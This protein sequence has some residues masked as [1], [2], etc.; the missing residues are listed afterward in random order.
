M[1]LST[2]KAKIVSSSTLSKTLNTTAVSADRVADSMREGAVAGTELA[3][4]AARTDEQASDLARSLGK[5]NSELA[6]GAA[7]GA[8]YSEALDSVAQEQA[9]ASA[10]SALLESRIES[11]G[12][13]ATQSALKAR[14]FA[15]ALDGI[16]DTGVRASLGGISGGLSGI[17][18]AA[19]A[20][21]PALLGVG[22]AAGGIVGGGAL[23]AGGGAALFAGGIRKKAERLA[24]T[25]AEFQNASEAT[26]AIWG[27]VKSQIE[28]ATSPLQSAR[29]ATFATENLEAVIELSG[30]A[31]TELANIQDTLFPLL[32]GFRS[33]ALQ[34]APAAFDALGDS[35]ERLSPLLSGANSLIREVPDG[36]RYF[37][38]AAVQLGPELANLTSS[39][40]RLGGALGRMGLSIGK[41]VLPP[42]RT[43]FDIVSWGVGLFNKLPGPVKQ[44]GVAATIAAGGVTLLTGSV[45]GLA[46]ALS[47]T[48]IPQTALALG[49]LAGVLAGLEARFG[50]V[51][52]AVDLATA[53]WNILVEGVE[54]GINGVIGTANA[55]DNLLGRFSP[56]LAAIS[57]VTYAIANWSEIMNTAGDIAG[58]LGARIRWL[59][60]QVQRY[61]GPVV[62]TIGKVSDRIDEAGGVELDAV[63]INDSDPSGGDVGT[64]PGG[65]GNSTES[66]LPSSATSMS[67]SGITIDMSNSEFGQS[68][69]QEMRK[70]AREI[71]KEIRASSR[72]RE[73]GHPG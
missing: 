34:T 23:A 64:S 49:A 16:D 2:L 68:D 22:A 14:A 47:A 71:V 41:V 50:A 72:R 44:A 36:V 8:V 1:E 24:A 43:M 40:V 30:M 27:E 9:E 73:S 69:E 26:E 31:A 3:T 55:I 63:K 29:A 45:A 13:E 28:A 20:A 18:T 54:A 57:P 51:S 32:S 42:L 5:S 38:N 37:T 10:A 25:S 48:G 52:T 67:D 56:L 59:S 21:T 19:A 17:A 46:A 15:H 39:A 66:A 7:Q 70:I 62:E 6:E 58:W 11:V 35:V 65:R 61:M 53:R 60:R 4:A 12:D 33:T